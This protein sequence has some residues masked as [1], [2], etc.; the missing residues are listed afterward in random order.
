[1]A[2]QELENR[3]GSWLLL[4][5]GADDLEDISGLWH[6]TTGQIP[7]TFFT[8]CNMA[9]YQ[10]FTVF[11]PLYKVRISIGSTLHPMKL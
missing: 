10:L 2:L 8:Y 6:W 4:I 9:L 3:K 7:E 11:K 5:D 1:M